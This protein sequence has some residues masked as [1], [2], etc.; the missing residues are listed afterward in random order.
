MKPRHIHYFMPQGIGDVIMSIPVISEIVKRDKVRISISVK[1]QTEAII[2]NELCQ[3]IEIDFIIL[4]EIFEQNSTPISFLKVI[5]RLR[6][7]SPDIIFT[8][9][10]LMYIIINSENFHKQRPTR[11]YSRDVGLLHHTFNYVYIF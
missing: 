3:N 8:Q 2:I 7:L 11:L 6:Q 9:F 4:N 5:H 1:S 10:N